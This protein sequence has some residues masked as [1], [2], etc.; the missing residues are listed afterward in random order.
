[1]RHN[2]QRHTALLTAEVPQRLVDL[3]TEIQQL[4]PSWPSKAAVVR[5]AMAYGVERVYA[6]MQAMLR[7]RQD[8]WEAAG[9]QAPAIGTVIQ[10]PDAAFSPLPEAPASPDAS[11]PDQ[12]DDPSP[13]APAT[14]ADQQPPQP[15]APS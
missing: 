12:P 14:T 10:P 8:A 13:G 2:P 9:K 15:P 11:G 1:M 3:I 7:A 6:D 4:H 5:W